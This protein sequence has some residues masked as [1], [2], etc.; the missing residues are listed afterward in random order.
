MRKNGR[1]TGFTLLEMLVVVAIIGMLVGLLL[2]AVQSVR[3]QARKTKARHDVDQLATAWLAYL[4][5]YRRFPG[6]AIVSTGSNAVNI[7]SGVTSPD[8]PRGVHFMEFVIS[9]TN[10]PDPW[11]HEYSIL[12]DSDYDNKVTHPTLGVMSLSVAVWSWGR[13]GS[14]GTPD[15]VRNWHD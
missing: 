2:P 4:E 6:T 1:R 9:A 5:E 8:N 14:N 3:N 13:D 10:F 12:L 7:L 15:D 11:G